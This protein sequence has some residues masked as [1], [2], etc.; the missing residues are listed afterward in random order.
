MR[1]GFL[2]W[3]VTEDEARTLAECIRAVI[4]ICAAVVGQGSPKFWELADT[5]P[6]VSRMEGAEPRYQVDQ[7]KTVLPAEPPITPVQ[8]QEETLLALRS[9]DY[10]V[11]GV[12][13]LDLT[14]A[15]QRSGRRANA[16]PAP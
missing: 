16:A 15:V 5:Y 8:L 14:T 10:A 4:V 7:V 11:R 6:M 3:F 2:P 12:M 13:E 9:Q 1:P